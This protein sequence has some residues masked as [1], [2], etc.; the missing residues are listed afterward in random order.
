MP[1]VGR[2]KWTTAMKKAKELAAKKAAKG[3]MSKSVTYSRPSGL[4]KK[5]YKRK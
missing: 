5:R 3:K 1:G 2:N 4:T